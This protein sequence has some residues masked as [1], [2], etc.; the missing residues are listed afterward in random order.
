MSGANLQLESLMVSHAPG[1]SQNI[2]ITPS[3][4]I[5]RHASCIDGTYAGRSFFATT[6][7]V[8]AGTG[9]RD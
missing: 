8:S 2:M 1:M 5:L 3:A 9:T 7:N 4:K 6:R